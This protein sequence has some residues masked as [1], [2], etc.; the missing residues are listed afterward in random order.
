MEELYLI[1]KDEIIFVIFCNVYILKV[2][3]N[4][5]EILFMGNKELYCLVIDFMFDSFKEI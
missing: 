1:N 5:V 2:K 3:I 4:V